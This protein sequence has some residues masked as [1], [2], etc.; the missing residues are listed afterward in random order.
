MQ[1]VLDRAQGHEQ[2]GLQKGRRSRE[3]EVACLL[4]WHSSFPLLFEAVSA[5]GMVLPGFRE[6][7][8]SLIKPL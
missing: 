1:S 5:H 2:L 8:L 6:G 3:L 4:H 7:L